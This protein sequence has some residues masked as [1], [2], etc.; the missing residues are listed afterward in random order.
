M[1]VNGIDVN[2]SRSN[3]IAGLIDEGAHQSN[4]DIAKSYSGASEGRGLLNTPDHMNSQLSYG[5]DA[6]SQAIKQRTDKS[7]GRFEKALSLK[8]VMNADSDHV[9]NLQV[10]SQL[11]NQEV[12]TN[13][14]KEL[15][16]D[17][18][19]QANKRARGQVVGNVL[20]IVGAV[21]GAVVG[22][23]ATGGAGAAAGGMAGY[24]GGQALGQG[25]GGS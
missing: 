9:R 17:K 21:A 13:M 8:T 19:S 14:Q 7:Y 22:G 20:G 1:D 23:Y 25:I 18:I 4:A 6:Q 10:A 15:L 24:Q 3:E 12:Q 2:S 11:A 16:R 5:N